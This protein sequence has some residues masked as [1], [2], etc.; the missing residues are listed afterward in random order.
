MAELHHPPKPCAECP[1]RRDQPAGRFPAERY[2]AMRGTS[3]DRDGSAPLGAPLFACHKTREDAQVACAGWLAVEG[4]GHV[5]VR[6]AVATGR[7]DP[8]ALHPGSDWPALYDS[9][10]ELAAVN[11]AEED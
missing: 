2:E 1:W 8:V 5:G 9:Y 7:L 3:A 11:G 6:L 10:D 4:H